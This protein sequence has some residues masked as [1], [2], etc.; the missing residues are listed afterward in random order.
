[1][2]L[3]HA[4]VK[5]AIYVGWFVLGMAIGRG[6]SIATKDSA[7]APPAVEAPSL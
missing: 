5:T 2:N 1:M 7:A 6:V 3:K 4:L